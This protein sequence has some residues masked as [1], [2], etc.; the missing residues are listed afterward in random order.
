ILWSTIFC[1][2]FGLVAAVFPTQIMSLFTK[3]DTEMIHVGA[4]A[5]RAN[6]LSFMLF[7]FYTVYSF[8]FLVMGKAKE[9]CILG[10]CRQGICFVPV[11]WLLPMVWGLNGVLYAQ[12][13]AD[14]LAAVVALLMALKLHRKMTAEGFHM[15]AH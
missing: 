2:I 4:A 14:V 1:V 10:A 15:G 5:L 7:G 13:V 9:G 12:P 11:I 6:G 3:G 8:L